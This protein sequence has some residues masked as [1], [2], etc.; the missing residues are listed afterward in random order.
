MGIDYDTAEEFPADDSGYGFDNVGDA[1]T[2]SPLL[3]EKYLDAAETI[4]AEAVPAQEV[5]ARLVK[6]Y[7]QYRRFFLHGPA[8]AEPDK[9]GAYAREIL[10][11]FTRRAYRRPADKETIDRLTTLAKAGFTT[12]GQTFEAGISR[13]MVAVLA[14]PRFLFHVEGIAVASAGQ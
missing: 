5:N 4:V 6:Q 2:M 11:V 12:P 3:M 13:A 14:S 10:D 8:P 7:E 1:L 9:R